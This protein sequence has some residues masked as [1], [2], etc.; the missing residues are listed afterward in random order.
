MQWD[1]IIWY[2]GL[3]G[4]EVSLLFPLQYLIHLGPLEA[5]MWQN[6]TYI[7]TFFQEEAHMYF[8]WRIHALYFGMGLKKIQ[9]KVHSG[10]CDTCQIS[11][12]NPLLI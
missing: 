2:E 5:V 1:A 3:F 6:H 9:M 4:V 10:G 12:P 7:Q 11:V 8:L